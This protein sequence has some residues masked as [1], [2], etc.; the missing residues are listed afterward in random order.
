MKSDYT[1]GDIIDF[2]DF[3]ARTF[4]EEALFKNFLQNLQINLECK[5]MDRSFSKKS[6]ITVL[7]TIHLRCQHVLGGE[8]Y[9]HVPM[10]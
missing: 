1:E 10:V 8:G 2:R 7:G 5:R 6:I 4:T 3:F 9:P